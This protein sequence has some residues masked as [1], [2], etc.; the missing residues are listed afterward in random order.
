MFNKG[1]HL[2]RKELKRVLNRLYRAE[3][4]RR[5]PA[6]DTGIGLAVSRSLA[7]TLGGSLVADD[8]PD[9]ASFTLW[10]PGHAP[11]EPTASARTTA[12]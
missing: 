11:V 10:L 12:R 6:A 8:V 3:D 7:S 1:S 5:S 2:D 4:A 9:G